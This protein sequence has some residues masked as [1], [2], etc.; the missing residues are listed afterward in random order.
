MVSMDILTRWYGV[1]A[2]C[3]LPA[4]CCLLPAACCLLPAA[5]CLKLN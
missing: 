2:C 4:A 3:L 1:A 5:C